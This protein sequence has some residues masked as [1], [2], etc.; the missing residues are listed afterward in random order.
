M[1][2]RNSALKELLMIRS[3]TESERARGGE[4]EGEEEREEEREEEGARVAAGL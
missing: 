1:P 4:G 3:F 2:A